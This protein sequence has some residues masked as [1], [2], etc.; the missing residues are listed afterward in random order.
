MKNIKKLTAFIASLTLAVCAVPMASSAESKEYILTDGTVVHSGDEFLSYREAYINDESSDLG[1]VNRDGCINGVD[2]NMIMEYYIKLYN[3]KDDYYTEEEH[4][5]FR[6]YGDVFNDGQV[7][8][9]DVSWVF[10][11]ASAN[12]KLIDNLEEIER[13]S[14]EFL[15]LDYTQLGGIG[16]V[17]HDGFVDARDA[18]LVSLYYAYLSTRS[19]ENEKDDHKV[20]WVEN[21]QRIDLT[22]D[23]N[24][25]YDYTEE[26]IEDMYAYGDV[27]KDGCV[28]AIDASL[29]ATKYAKN[30]TQ[31]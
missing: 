8:I 16:D 3:E 24:A 12:A 20:I 14:I 11:K 30:S 17:N 7:D 21:E 28:N 22:D 26:Q 13:R 18:T 25:F 4:E 23:F 15:E 2:T 9:I 31:G 5:I 6:K 27:N 1:D 10:A 29:I 19:P